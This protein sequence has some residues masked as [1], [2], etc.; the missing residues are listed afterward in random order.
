MGNIVGV[1]RG[2]FGENFEGDFRG[3]FGGRF[4]LEI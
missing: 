3:S 4:R 1:S 2:S